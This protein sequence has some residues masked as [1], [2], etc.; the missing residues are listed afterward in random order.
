MLPFKKYN[1]YHFNY[2]LGIGDLNKITG[3]KFNERVFKKIPQYIYMGALDENDAVQY[4][5][6]YNAEER[7]IINSNLG[8]EVQ[9]RWQKNQELYKKEGINARFTTYEKVGHQTTSKV[10]LD[11]ILFFLDWI[12]KEQLL[13][14]K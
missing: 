2:P 4:D 1:Q 10:N 14:G 13:S 3:K 9:K 6:A 7:H 11:V 5:D 8:S 12:K